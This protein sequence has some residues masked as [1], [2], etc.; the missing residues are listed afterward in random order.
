MGL[1]HVDD[2]GEARMVDVSGKPVTERVAVAE[3]IVAMSRAAYEQVAANTIAKGDVLAVARLAGTMAAKRTG[4]LIPLCHPIPIDGIEVS[5]VLKPAIPGV[6][7]QATVRSVGRTGVEMEALLGASIACLTVYDMVKAVDR[8]T[9]IRA[10]RLVAKSG[11]RSGDY[12]RPGGTE[13]DVP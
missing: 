4:E 1:S 7:I 8:A 11:G 6:H 2:A 3:G 12:R 10:V 5:A 9:E 13:G